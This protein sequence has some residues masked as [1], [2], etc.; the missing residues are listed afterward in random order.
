MRK[1]LY[2]IGAVALS[3]AL[4][5]GCTQTTTP[6]ATA[7]GRQ[8]ASAWLTDNDMRIS[9]TVDLTGGYSVEFAASAVYLYDQEIKDDTACAAMAVTV[10]E[11]TYNSYLNDA[12]QSDT[13]RDVEGGVVY[14]DSNDDDNYLVQAGDNGYLLLSM[15][16]G[17]DNDALYSRFS[18]EAESTAGADVYGPSDLYTVEEQDAAVAEIAEEFLTWKGCELKD[19]RYAGDACN[20]EENL[21]WLNSLKEGAGYTQCIEFLTDF[22]SPTEEADLEGT[23]WEPDTD[24]NDYQWWLGRADGG[25]WE[26]V[27]WG[28]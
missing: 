14:T 2:W 11:E 17:E 23:A 12:R 18:F 6:A 4:L 13:C 20:T 24:Y 8:T 9:A 5:G 25:Q 26:L 1:A 15:H 21:Q 27:S 16:H 28:Y 19:V 3:A 7:E 10:D 22:H